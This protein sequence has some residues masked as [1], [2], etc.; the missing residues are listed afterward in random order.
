MPTIESVNNLKSKEEKICNMYVLGLSSNK[1]AKELQISTSSVKKIL[2]KHN[3]SIRDSSFSHQIY[4][5]NEDVF[6]N[7]DSHE[8]AYWVGF[9]TA[10]GTIT[11]G[12]LKLALATK[13]INHLESFKK[14]MKSTHPILIYKQIPSETSMVKNKDKEYFYG[15]IGFSNKKLIQDLSKYSVT[16]RKSFT[17]KF[18][19]NIPN[20]YLCSYMAGLIDADGFI[21]VCNKIITIGFLSHTNFA[22]NFNKALHANLDISN[23]TLVSHHSSDKIKIVR[24][25]GKQVFS[26]GKFLYQNT[27]I[28]LERKKNKIL[29]FFQENSF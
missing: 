19:Q 9:L 3:V 13:D 28:F 4:N 7:I 16:K 25:S 5:V 15:I 27:P 6:E 2:K 23:N 10:D 14:F 29:N 18:A 1:I 21:T 22:V 12:R 20:E 26:I 17:V 11:G 8:K 24:F